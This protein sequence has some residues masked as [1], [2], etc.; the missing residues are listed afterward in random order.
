MFLYDELVKRI[1]FRPGAENIYV[2]QK[3]IWSKNLFFCL[4]LL[5]LS[6]SLPAVSLETSWEINTTFSSLQMG[7]M[8]VFD[9]RESLKQ[10]PQ[11]LNQ[12]QLI[13]FSL[14]VGEFYLLKN[15]KDAYFNLVS[16]LKSSS[17]DYV[18]LEEL[19]E[20]FWR[21]EKGD[22]SQAESNF[23]EYL[24]KES[25][26]Y[27][28]SLGNSFYNQFSKKKNSPK[29]DLNELRNLACNR[30]K[31]YFTL[32]RLTKLRAELEI[33]GFEV[34]QPQ[35]EYQILD[36]LLAPFFEDNDLTYIAFLDQMIPDLSP[37]LAYLGFAGEAVHFQK[38]LLMAEKLGSKFD[39][40]VH[41]RLAFYQLLQN[42]LDAAEDTLYSSLKN[43]RTLSIIRN[44][45]LL[46]LGAI[47]FLR[48]DYEQ[49]L[50]YFTGLNLKYWGRTLRHPI[51]DDAI[52]PNGA[53]EM[54][55]LVISLG[56]NTGLAVEVLN[57]L[58]STKVDEEDLFIRLRIAQ[59]MIKSR[60][61][62]SEK[63][64]DDIIYTAQSKGWK[65]LEYAATILNGYA[66]IINKKHRKAVVQFT[67]SGGILGSGDSSYASE[68]VRLSGMLTARVQ[69]KEAGNHSVSYQKL[70]SLLKK[71]I[72]SQ[73]E[74]LL[75][76]YLD[77]RF[78]PEEFLK[79]AQSYF[80]STRDYES[81][82]TT[83]HLENSQ[84]PNVSY[85]KTM[86]QVPEVHKR[87]KKFRGFRPQLDNIYYMGYQSKAR[88]EI[89]QKMTQETDELNPGFIKKLNDPFIAIFPVGETV[90]LI[91]YQPEK[92]RWTYSVLS[93]SEYNTSSY[94]NKI[95]NSFLFIDKGSVFQIYLNK[96]GLDLY[97][98]LKKNGYA[99]HA[100]LF[101]SFQHGSKKEPK[102][103]ET[104]A[105]DCVGDKKIA[106]FNYYPIDYYDGTKTFDSQAR[107]QIWKFSEIM[108]R[109]GTTKLDTYSWRCDS[110]NAL[111]FLRME[112]RID[113]KYTPTSILIAN[114]LLLESNPNY[115]GTDYIS[116]VDF[117][118]RKGTSY[119]Y[120]LDKI[121][122][123]STTVEA[124]KVFTKQYPEN[125]DFL[126][127]Q[128]SLIANSRD[129]LILL[130]E[131]R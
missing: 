109:S 65:R 73:D 16:L 94:Y 90:N 54:I 97:Q 78:S 126:Q 42:D 117:W 18:L 45:I 53:R 131:P 79:Q 68:W 85:K 64:T 17:N 74:M 58:K 1:F 9:S 76:M 95:L 43:L 40:V 7:G 62:L 96:S 21:K 52:T 4:L 6:F 104:V 112:R 87:T 28:L 11:N 19:M 61:A 22:Q 60:P 114:P 3:L 120:F 82:L 31:S 125:S 12:D 50:I 48:K 99:S 32:C 27:F 123:D 105:P 118:M 59:I 98:V 55:A 57:R 67:K 38:M 116:W 26:P 75:K 66:C 8:K 25:N 110:K 44:G 47:A 34:T 121:E 130:R 56:K 30:N 124:L 14:L 51:I 101:F 36:R 106:S 20:Y 80:L 107:L 83:L 93:S 89:Y 113:S 69:G 77:S 13:D 119:L 72:G 103:L 71:E 24:R 84:R 35:R 39:V 41:E 5:V 88:E 108:N 122:N 100:R 111:S 70:I 23:E 63:I 91:G 127:I 128:D 81:L 49:S 129:G 33:L 29:L 2:L 10:L 46:K 37:K 92:N 86:L 115:L 15:D 102:D